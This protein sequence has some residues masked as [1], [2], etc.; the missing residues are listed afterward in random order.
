[1]GFDNIELPG[2]I[3]VFDINR[4]GEA[5]RDI[6]DMDYY[7]VSIITDKSNPMFLEA[8]SHYPKE[9]IDCIIIPCRYLTTFLA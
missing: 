2:P 7:P 5:I 3:L 9:N 4:L 8:K 6:Y 1:M